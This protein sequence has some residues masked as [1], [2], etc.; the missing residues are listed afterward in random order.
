MRS[1]I[2]MK[3]WYLRPFISQNLHCGCY[4]HNLSKVGARAWGFRRLG[5]CFCKPWICSICTFHMYLINISTIRVA[6]GSNTCIWESC[7]ATVQDGVSICIRKTRC[8]DNI[9]GTGLD[10]TGKS[11]PLIKVGAKISP[12][13]VHLLRSWLTS[14]H[15]WLPNS[16]SVRKQWQIMKNKWTIALR[17]TSTDYLTVIQWN[18]GVLSTGLW[19]GGGYQPF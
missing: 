10:P 4:A 5:W 17:G 13:L 7:Q 2:E 3:R 16:M 18:W 8:C 11:V 1:Q 9:L 6:S 14:G 12:A 19:S 15:V